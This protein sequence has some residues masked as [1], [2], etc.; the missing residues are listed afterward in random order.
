MPVEEN[1]AQSSVASGADDTKKSPPSSYE[2]EEGTRLG[3]KE[4][5]READ[6]QKNEDA[7]ER[8]DNL[9]DGT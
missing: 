9:R 4:D 6:T 8:R 5:S 3:T 7:P 1:D 2:K